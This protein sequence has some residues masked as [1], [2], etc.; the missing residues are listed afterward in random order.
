M[1][2]A[3]IGG[4]GILR[5][6]NDRIVSGLPLRR[7]RPMLANVSRPNHAARYLGQ[8]TPS[9][10]VPVSSGAG[11]AF[12]K[13]VGVPAKR[14]CYVSDTGNPEKHIYPGRL[15]YLVEPNPD[16]KKVSQDA[17]Y[18]VSH[19]LPGVLGKVKLYKLEGAFGAGRWYEFPIKEREA[20]P[21]GVTP[22]LLR[23]FY[24]VPIGACNAVWAYIGIQPNPILEDN[25]ETD[26]R[27]SPVWF[28]SMYKVASQGISDLPSSPEEIT[29]KSLEG[30][31]GQRIMMAYTITLEALDYASAAYDVGIIGIR[32]LKLYRR[33]G[34]E[35]LGHIIRIYSLL[36]EVTATDNSPAK[37][38]LQVRDRLSKRGI[39]HGAYLARA[40]Y[41]Q[42]WSFALDHGEGQDVN[43][44]MRNAN[45]QIVLAL[46]DPNTVA[47]VVKSKAATEA[48]VAKVRELCMSGIRV[49]DG[50]VAEYE[51]SIQKI[52]ADAGIDKEDCYTVAFQMPAYLQKNREE[53][54]RI[55]RY[56]AGEFEPRRKETCLDGLSEAVLPFTIA[57]G[58]VNGIPFFPAIEI[59]KAASALAKLFEMPG[60]IATL[61]FKSVVKKAWGKARN[62]SVKLLKALVNNIVS[63]EKNF[64]DTLTSEWKSKYKIFKFEDYTVR[65]DELLKKSKEEPDPVAAAEFKRQYEELNSFMNSQNFSRVRNF[66]E[67]MKPRM[68]VPEDAPVE[69]KAQAEFEI[70]LN[71]SELAGVSYTF[72]PDQVRLL[73]H[74]LYRESYKDAPVVDPEHWVTLFENLGKREKSVSIGDLLVESNEKVKKLD[75]WLG[76]SQPSTSGNLEEMY[77]QAAVRAES[78]G[79]MGLKVFSATPMTVAEIRK[80]VRD[81]RSELLFQETMQIGMMA[82]EARTRSGAISYPELLE[83]P[84][85]TVPPPAPEPTP[86]PA[87]PTPTPTPP[88]RPDIVPLT[89]RIPR[90]TAEDRASG[91]PSF[92][93]WDRAVKALDKGLQLLSAED[94]GKLPDTS[95]DKP[96]KKPS[97]ETVFKKMAEYEGGKLWDLLLAQMTDI[98]AKYGKGLEGAKGRKQVAEITYLVGEVRGLMSRLVGLGK[99]YRTF[100]ARK[101]AKGEYQFEVPPIQSEVNKMWDLIDQALSLQERTTEL[102]VRFNKAITESNG[103]WTE[104]TWLH[105]WKGS[106]TV[107]NWMT[108]V[109]TSAPEFKVMDKMSETLKGWAVVGII[110]PL[111]FYAAKLI[112]ICGL[113]GYI[114]FVGFEKVGNL[115]LNA[116]NWIGNKIPHGRDASVP[117]GTPMNLTGGED[118]SL[119]TFLLFALGIGMIF[120]GKPVF[121]AINETVG[122]FFKFATAIAPGTMAKKKK[123]FPGAPG[124]GGRRRG[125]PY[126]VPALL[127]KHELYEA[128]VEKAKKA[129][130]KSAGE[131]ARRDL[132]EVIEKLKKAKEEGQEVP[133]G[134]WGFKWLG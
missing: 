82:P 133:P 96:K 9:V 88:T 58:L 106:L 62:D 95:P 42:Q 12:A 35:I 109:T 16:P 53:I 47:A 105:T 60:K 121:D 81:R 71:F 111:G 72:K 103:Y 130:S 20:T 85:E 3:R 52:M 113:L 92:E 104:A 32:A 94:L 44:A 56:L 27:L 134:L 120:Y 102:D 87:P 61:D 26:E 30:E 107:L 99:E 112:T 11:L 83:P 86:T 70:L 101:D 100:V 80:A 14:F 49:F 89:P 15:V 91:P 17:L 122:G 97:L 125:A 8:A 50:N 36:N 21:E 74:I 118:G 1:R 33:I 116:V 79:L 2:T 29:E 131:R 22:A 31:V 69:A 18:L 78:F 110:F 38:A 114:G 117:N 126:D 40:G 4:D 90:P 57:P 64:V 67:L 34:L 128:R 46:S 51:T 24:V 55:Y 108:N 84:V 59:R 115:F 41:Y 7:S 48:E 123:G 129:G 10:P 75:L 77:P 37:K 66:A 5:D 19:R 13:K 6:A 43:S 63:S 39:L 76:P 45:A 65:L 25:L 54:E 93:I 98:E 23:D 28:S 119:G 132:D 127:N 68:Q 124:G 73:K